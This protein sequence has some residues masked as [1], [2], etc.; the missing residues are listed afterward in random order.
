MLDC[1]VIIERSDIIKQGLINIISKY[2]VSNKICTF[3]SFNEYST[4]ACTQKHHI[5][6]TNPN[7]LYESVNK[8]KKHFNVLPE[9][10]FIATV[11]SY[12]EKDIINAF[13]EI[14]YIDDS[15]STIINKIKACT[16]VK[17]ISA[18]GVL[19]KREIEILKELIKGHTNKEVA[20]ALHLSVHTI[21]THR[22]N[23]MEK[24]G[25]KSLS[26]LAVYAIVNNIMDIQEIK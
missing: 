20:S 22:K 12:L 19:S 23:I 5:I 1:I 13:D 10:C 9:T 24:T 7:C 25:I 17:T 15:P 18:E 6:I 21:I 4:K 16:N 2:R 3:N 14:L 11:Y 26:G 8:T